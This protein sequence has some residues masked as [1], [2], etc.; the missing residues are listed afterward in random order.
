MKSLVAALQLMTRLPMPRIE[1]EAHDYARAIRWFPL[2]GLVLGLCLALA[3]FV[4][5]RLLGGGQGGA[6][7]VLL[8]WVSVTGALHLDGLGDIADGA[9]AAHA[10][11][12]RLSAVLAD[13]HAGSFAVTVIALQLIAKFAL[14]SIFLD[15][16]GT[17]PTALAAIACVPLAARIAPLGWALWLP[18]LHEG[19]GSRFGGGANWQTLV[20]WL[21]VLGLLAWLVSPAL[22]CAIPA[23]LVWGT[24]LRRRIGGISG[25]GHGGGIEVVE[26]LVLAV[27]VVS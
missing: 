23:A 20:V 15:R 16:E 18:A 21:L 1:A 6:L 2:A 22:L 17:T 5:V 25:D 27:M 12:E 10:G 3:A 7:L 13:P 11:R 9:G 8:T 26:T 19:M 4:G 14:L 24:W